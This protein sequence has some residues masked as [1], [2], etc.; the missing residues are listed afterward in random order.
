MTTGRAQIGIFQTIRI[1]N[2][3][4]SVRFDLKKLDPFTLETSTN[5]LIRIISGYYV[6]YQIEAFCVLPNINPCVAMRHDSDVD[7]A[8]FHL[9]AGRRRKSRT[10]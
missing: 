2:L 9:A 10:Q 5:N 7:R 8:H 1:K 4:G 6:Q 3:R